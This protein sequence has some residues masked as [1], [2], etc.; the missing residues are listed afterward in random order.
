MMK[1]GRKLFAGALLVLYIVLAA[2]CNSA[3]TNTALPEVRNNGTAIQWKYSDETDWRD[4][5]ALSE[6]RGAAG[7]NG[8]DGA[9]GINGKNGRPRNA[10]VCGFRLFEPLCFW[11]LRRQRRL[12]RR[13][14]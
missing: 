7:A 12:Y 3:K 4:L 9:D 5:V 14:H 11:R 6:L 10:T 13:H 1:T 2:G 8:K